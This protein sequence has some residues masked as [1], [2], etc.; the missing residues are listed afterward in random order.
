MTWLTI[1]FIEYWK[2][3]VLIFHPFLL[4]TSSPHGDDSRD[5]AIKKNLCD[6]EKLFDNMAKIDFIKLNGVE[7]SKRRK[8]EN[9]ILAPLL[10]KPM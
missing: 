1:F 4:Y 3:T 10:V 5:D 7:A 6:V 2:K 9:A 8:L